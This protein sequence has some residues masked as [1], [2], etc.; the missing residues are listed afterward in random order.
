MI[1]TENREL[2]AGRMEKISRIVMERRA[3]RVNEL[4]GDLGVSPATVRRDLVDMERR[5]DIVRVH[6]G[7]I[8][9]ESLLDEP[10][11][12]DKA[13]IAAD[14]KQAIAEA[15]RRFVKPKDSIFLD[16]G[17]TVLALARL[18]IDMRRLTVVTNS[19]RVA[20]TFA[21]KG[22]RTIVVGGELRRLS[23]TFVGPL[24]HPLIEQLHVDTAFMG[25]IG[26]S[27]EQ[28]MT[29]TDPR[30]A[31]TKSLVV[32]HAGKVIL[33]AD[34]TKLGRVSFV[35]SGVPDDIDVLITDHGA[36]AGTIKKIRKS[37]VEVILCR[38]N[39]S[40]CPAK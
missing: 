33:L 26:L 2:A 22:P 34:S 28:G 15:A 3:V 17:S 6:G 4:S 37:G 5:G 11:F 39:N 16:G 14:A 20:G 19:L 12:D 7:A 10:V 27:I 24:A 35:R 31:Q 8:C 9:A 30:E 29:T 13:S 23:Q 32:A 38:Q 21:A 36:P 25:T 1:T 40:R 18:L